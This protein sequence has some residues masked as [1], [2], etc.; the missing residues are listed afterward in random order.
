[1]KPACSNIALPEYDHLAAL[2]LLAEMG[3]QGLEVAPSRVW[4]ETEKVTFSKVEAYRHA[5]ESAGLR[6]L[7][8]H[9]L[10]FHAPE[11]MLFKDV[12]TRNKL[13]EYLIVKAQLCVDL[14]GYSLI[15]GSPQSRRRGGLAIEEAMCIASDFFSTLVERTAQ[16]NIAF[17]LEPLSPSETDFVDSASYAIDLARRISHP[18]FRIQL[19]AKSLVASNEDDETTFESARPWLVHFHANDPGLVVLDSTKQ[20]DH[21]HLGKLLRGINYEGYVSLEQRMLSEA[22][23]LEALTQSCSVMKKWY[24]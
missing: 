15:F 14:G 4:R 3:F 23:P 5:V 16:M 21:S 11:L 17:C 8:L 1:M 13:L 2:P 12:G 9:S 24:S 22:D 6:V 19:D 18:N 10:T 7:G 20:V